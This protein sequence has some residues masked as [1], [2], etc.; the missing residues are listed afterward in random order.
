MALSTS[1]M[2]NHTVVFFQKDSGVVFAFPLLSARIMRLPGEVRKVFQKPV[3][4]IPTFL[5]ELYS[6]GVPIFAQLNVGKVVP[7][8]KALNLSVVQTKT[9]TS[10]FEKKPKQK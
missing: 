8:F 2:L 6:C 10:I 4:P 1:K 9:D 7:S 3:H 5:H